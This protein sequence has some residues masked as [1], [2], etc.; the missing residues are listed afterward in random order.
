MV[1]GVLTADS[2]SIS[3]RSIGRPRM[4][5]LSPVMRF[6]GSPVANCCSISPQLKTRSSPWLERSLKKVLVSGAEGA[7]D[8]AN[9]GAFLAKAAGCGQYMIASCDMHFHV[10]IPSASLSSTN[11]RMKTRLLS[12][13]LNI[14][15]RCPCALIALISSSLSAFSTW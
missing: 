8:T 5:E 14:D 6:T 9:E 1:M 2:S 11:A 4:N 12:S 7:G 15:A 10:N 13:L 3:I